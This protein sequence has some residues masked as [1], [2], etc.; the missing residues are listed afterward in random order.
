MYEQHPQRS[1]VLIVDDVPENLHTLMSILR[2][3]YA[4][5]AATSGKKALELARRTPH[6]DLIL[7][8]IKMPDMDGYTV[9]ERL[10]DDPAT[11][12]IP[13][14]FIT[15]MGDTDDVARGLRLGVVDYIVKPVDPEM[16]R[17][18]VRMQFD[19][20]YAQKHPAMRSFDRV[21]DPEQRPRLLLVDDVPENLHELTEALMD[22]YQIQIASNGAKALEAVQGDTPPDLVLL[23]VVMPGMDGYEICRR[24][25]SL[26]SGSS[27]PVIFVTV[28]DSLEQKVSGFN[29]GAADYITKPYDIDEVRARIR[30]HL[31]LGRLRYFLEALVAQRTE[32]LHG[33]EEKYH[34]VANFTHD[35]EYWISPEGKMRYVS[36]SCERLTGY[37]AEEFISTPA[38]VGRIVHRD[39]RAEFLKHNDKLSEPGP[40]DDGR[41]FRII[42]K[43]GEQ[44]WIEHTGVSVFGADGAYL[45]RRVSN[46]DMTR[47]KEAEEEA[48]RLTAELEQRVQLR[49]QELEAA[50]I[51]LRTARDAAEAA[52]AA[53]TAFLSNMSHEI[54]TPLNAIIG[55]VDIMRRTG[56][57][58]SQLDRLD[59]IEAAGKHLTSVISDILDLS[60]IE[61]GKL[62]IDEAAV[63]VDALVSNVTSMLRES[64]QSKD[65][66]LVA[67][68]L[69]NLPPLL[70]DQ[71]RLQQALINY[72]NNAAKFTQ[73]GKIT[74]RVRVLGES[75]NHSL[76]RFEVQD[77]GIGI[78]PEI[79]PN[80][81]SAFEQA[82]KST[83]RKYGGTGLGLAITQKL[84]HLMG[85]DAGALS[86]PEVGSTFWFTALLK[87]AASIP[88]TPRDGGDSSVEE[89]LQRDYS[90]RRLL[91]V[92]DDPFNQEITLYFLKRLG[93]Q[94]DVADDGKAAVE[95]VGKNDYD[96]VLMDVQM[97]TMNGLEATR[98]IRN[99]PDRQAVPI[100]AM[101][102]NAFAEDRTQCLEAGMNDFV[103]K[104]IESPALHATLLRWLANSSRAQ[105]H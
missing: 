49:T 55:M 27:I 41:E 16:L 98:A 60:K 76:L 102:A 58:K 21:F 22:Q 67:E 59:K 63:D 56:L 88:K 20:R 43:N 99:L 18:R 83:T 50:N 42:T 4:I 57:E 48:Q 75:A 97:P 79:L 10:R 89:R 8:D 47:R 39:D 37:S 65:L 81:F 82:D 105:P 90:G 30:T 46:R 69:P 93:M 61:A 31:E 101:T 68:P 96:L 19:L 24:I 77:T 34:T 52:T 23:D 95:L 91:I 17:L 3:S 25:K 62:D 66:K 29:I 86:T 26:P 44:R 11:A 94:C 73:S 14:I 85:G 15:G 53:K 92:D 6:P 13:V 35:W 74:V 71:T 1:S 54:R 100:L 70:G 5:A 9:L 33:S 72:T 104:P 7:L 28:A 38:L 45:G 78:R 2:D 36:P 40:P 32:Q 64:I 80:L 51:A 84:A 87:K 12:D 103:S